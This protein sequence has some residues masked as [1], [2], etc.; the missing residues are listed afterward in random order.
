MDIDTRIERS[1]RQQLNAVLPAVLESE[2]KI[3]LEIAPSELDPVAGGKSKANSRKG[4]PYCHQPAPTGLTGVHRKEDVW[5][6][7]SPVDS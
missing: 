1:A 4:R 3:S 6:G 7:P 5:P 2:I